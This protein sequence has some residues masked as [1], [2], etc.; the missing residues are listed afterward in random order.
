MGWFTSIF[1]VRLDLTGV[2]VDDAFA[3]GPAAAVALK[4][5][6]EQL[7]AI[8]DHGIGFG[9]LR[10]L[11]PETALPLSALP[12]PQ[13]SFNYLG[14][15]GAASSGDGDWTP[16]SE[17]G[18]AEA[19]HTGLP[20]PAAVDV[21]ART[22]DSGAGPELAATWAF[23]L[24]VLTTADVGELAQLWVSA[25]AALTTQVKSGVAVSPRPI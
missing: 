11:N 16:I 8:P 15:L 9:L 18:L 21:N 13:L 5:V 1:P 20:V 2:D 4:A 23:P 14:R 25:L 12:S 19:A 7:H 24:G 22:T 3:G 6:K 17:A 10:Y